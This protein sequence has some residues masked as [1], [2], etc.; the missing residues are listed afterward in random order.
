METTET[1][2]VVE[3]F[4]TLLTFVKSCA[5]LVTWA[6]AQVAYEEFIKTYGGDE[7][8]EF[9]DF[10]PAK[11]FEKL[12]WHAE[13]L[14]L[15]S[16]LD[17]LVAFHINY[18]GDFAR[19]VSTGMAGPLWLAEVFLVALGFARPAASRIRVAALETEFARARL[20][21]EFL[22]EHVTSLASE[23]DGAV[24]MLQ[25]LSIESWKLKCEVTVRVDKFAGFALTWMFHDDFILALAVVLSV[26]Q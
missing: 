23:C 21:G 18:D 12:V 11:C 13:G 4:K 25:K 22:Q 14:Q 26:K 5:R 17:I 19:F 16:T 7:A 24:P 9:L 1:N 20:K 6:S 15:L 2:R 3:Q 10:W 8:E